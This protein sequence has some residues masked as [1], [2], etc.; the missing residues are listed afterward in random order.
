[1]I[2]TCPRIPICCQTRPSL[3]AQ[4]VTSEQLMLT[5]RFLTGDL[6][7]RGFYIDIGVYKMLIGG[8]IWY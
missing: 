1:M 7:S 4:L 5:W 8:K 3:K 6:Y 2:Q